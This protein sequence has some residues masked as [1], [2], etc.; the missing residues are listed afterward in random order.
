VPIGGPPPKGVPAKVKQ[1]ADGVRKS[2]RVERRELQDLR[3]REIE[4]WWCGEALASTLDGLCEDCASEER[5]S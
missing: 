1:I 2:A 3:E 5:E 4:C